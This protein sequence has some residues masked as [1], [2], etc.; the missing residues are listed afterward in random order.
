MALKV[1]IVLYQLLANTKIKY[2]YFHQFFKLLKLNF[3]YYLKEIIFSSLDTFTSLRF[4]CVLSC[5]MWI[6]M[7]CIFHRYFKIEKII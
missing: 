7:A 3:D 4:I 1:N 6:I 2:C 5:E